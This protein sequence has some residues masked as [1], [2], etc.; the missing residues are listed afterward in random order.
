MLGAAVAP[1]IALAARTGG[2]LAPLDALNLALGVAVVQLF[3]WG[4][5]V[6]P[7]VGGVGLGP[8]R[9]PRRPG[10]RPRDRRAEGLR[11]ALTRARAW[12]ASRRSAGERPLR[13]AHVLDVG[14]DQPVVRAL[15]DHVRRPAGVARERE[16]RREQVR[17]EADA[18]QH[19]R[20]VVLDVGLQRPVRVLL[21]EDRAAR[22][23]RRR[24]PSSSQSGL[25]SID[26]ATLRSAAAR[27]SYARY[28]RW[29]KPI[30]RSPRA[31]VSR[32]HCSAFSGEPTSWICSTT[33]RRGAAVER[34]LHRAD[35]A[36]T[37]DARSDRVDGDHA[38]R[39]GGGVEAVLRADDEVR[40]ERPGRL[41][42]GRLAVDLVQEARRRGRGRGSGATG[43]RPWRMP[44]ERGERRRREGGERARLVRRGGHARIVRRA[45]HR[46]G[47]PQ[48]VHRLRGLR[49]RAEGGQHGVRHRLPR[50]ASR[51]GPT[52]RSTAGSATAE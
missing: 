45:P 48:R 2:I 4:V 47:R 41:G 50:A 13:G 30:S 42:V 7:A 18:H 17:R 33:S 44:R 8:G 6:G 35:R 10:A 15:L 3:L 1:L 37:A 5:A 11:P 26:S 39:E 12:P 40:V 34:P 49:Q 52:R 24:S 16:R 51:P 21:G 28:T 22:R 38:A 32:T 46:D 20:R 31:S 36:D 27:G 9:R 19:R 29:P 23:P 14:P 25:C 43:S